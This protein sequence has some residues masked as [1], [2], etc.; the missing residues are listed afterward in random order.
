MNFYLL[1]AIAFGPQVVQRLLAQLPHDRLDQ[2]LHSDRFTPREVVAH[3]A[4][5]E[6]IMRERI[7]TALANP[8]AEIPAYDEGQMA[9]DH[10]YAQQDPEAQV[11]VFIRE[12]CA[13]AAL[14]RSLSADEWERH[15]Y[16]PERGRQSVEDLAN[17]LLGHD[18]YHIEQ[19]TEYLG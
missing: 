18:L 1:P 13:T 2:A 10:H 3:L 7:R 16:H 9:L 8:G 5:W 4:D 11:E 6:P 15:V 19:L 12:R 14:L 17:T